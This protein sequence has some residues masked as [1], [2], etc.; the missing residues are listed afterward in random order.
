MESHFSIFFSALQL[1]ADACNQSVARHEQRL[2]RHERK[3]KVKVVLSGGNISNLICVVWI[4]K[5]IFQTEN[6]HDLF[7]AMMIFSGV[8]AK[9]EQAMVLQPSEG[10]QPMDVAGNA[11]PS[12]N[13]SVLDLADMQAILTAARAGGFNLEGASKVLPAPTADLPTGENCKERAATRNDE[14]VGDGDVELLDA[15]KKDCDKHIASDSEGS[16]GDS[17]IPEEWL[18]FR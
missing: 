12:N 6:A 8:V 2:L 15:D 1:V 11:A 17:L 4:I 10:V 18:A 14:N 5:I 9:F 16:D 3:D 7:D 13:R